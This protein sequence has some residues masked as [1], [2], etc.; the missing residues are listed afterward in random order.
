MFCFSFCDNAVT[1]RVTTIVNVLRVRKKGEALMVQSIKFDQARRFKDL[2]ARKALGAWLNF[3]KGAQ[4][5]VLI[6]GSGF[7]ASWLHFGLVRHFFGLFGPHESMTVSIHQTASRN[8][9]H[10]TSY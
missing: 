10:L 5:S 6:S 3:Q 8:Q 9:Q 7:P 1:I 4:C 2:A